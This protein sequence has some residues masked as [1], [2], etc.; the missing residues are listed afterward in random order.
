MAMTGPDE[1]SGDKV[2]GE[3]AGTGPWHSGCSVRVSLSVGEALGPAPFTYLQLL[4]SPKNP[5]GWLCFNIR[6]RF[7]TSAS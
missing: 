1:R 4:S 5:L 2:R 3:R 7:A 6:V